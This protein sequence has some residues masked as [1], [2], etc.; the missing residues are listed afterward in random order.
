MAKKNIDAIQ[1]ELINNPNL[2]SEQVDVISKLINNSYYNMDSVKYLMYYDADQLKVIELAA[3]EFNNDA[4]KMK[5]VMGVIDIDSINV[6]ELN[7]TQMYLK[8]IAIKN[9]IDTDIIDRIIDASIPYACSKYVLDAYL[10][11]YDLTDYIHY[12]PAQLYEIYSGAIDGINYKEYADQDIDAEIMGL[13]RHAMTLG[14]TCD[15]DC[16]TGDIALFK[17]KK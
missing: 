17:L 13:I 5:Y 2:N 1:E 16:D 14:F 11:G 8:F 7:A 12:D 15:Y 4:E 10:D 9:D 3:K 6:T